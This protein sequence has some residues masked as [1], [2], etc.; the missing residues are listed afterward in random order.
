MEIN[1]LLNFQKSLKEVYD[2]ANEVVNDL[3]KD[4]SEEDKKKYED[5]LNNS[6]EGKELKKNLDLLAKKK[7][8]MDKSVRDFENF[9]KK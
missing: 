8:E 1:A 2:T 6:P 4:M 9:N 7:E 3:Q 5:V